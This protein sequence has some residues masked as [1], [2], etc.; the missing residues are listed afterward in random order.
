MSWGEERTLIFH[1]TKNTVKNLEMALFD[2]ER[3]HTMKIHYNKNP[4]FFP[5]SFILSM[6][7]V[8]DH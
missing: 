1:P 6:I 7:L 2:P 8:T 3:V 4:L 5:I